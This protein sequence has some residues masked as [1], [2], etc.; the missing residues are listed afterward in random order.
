M[1]QQWGVMLGVTGHPLGF[2]EIIEIDEKIGVIVIEDP[3]R[4]RT[5]WSRSSWDSKF[6]EIYNTRE[7]AEE[8]IEKFSLSC[9]EGG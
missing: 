5:T 4:D 8:R 7:E 6:V 9:T 1:K 2:G 3:N